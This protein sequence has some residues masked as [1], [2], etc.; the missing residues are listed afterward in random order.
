MLIE[1]TKLEAELQECLGCRIACSIH[2]GELPELKM[3]AREAELFAALKNERRRSSW[4]RGRHVL[5][6]LLR[7]LGRNED[8]SEI[9]FPNRSLSL[10]HSA[11]CAVAVA[12]DV[13]VGTGIGVDLEYMRE[14]KDDMTRFFLC[15]PERAWFCAQPESSRNRQMIRLWTAKEAIFKSDVH[16]ESLTLIKYELADPSA[17][18]GGALINS[19]NGSRNFRY[20]SMDLGEAWLSVSVAQTEG[21]KHAL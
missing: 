21:S 20:A 12:L 3:N 10:S 5:K 1:E 19:E 7:R 15:D 2:C 4:I 11:D 16:N 13:S 6:N 14:T 9:S 18:R 8:T 17:D